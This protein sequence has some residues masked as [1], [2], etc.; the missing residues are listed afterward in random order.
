MII[1]V[2]DSYI[3]GY[4]VRSKA[5]SSSSNCIAVNVVLERLCF[6]FNGIPG[7]LSQSDKSPSDC[8]IE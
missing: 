7:S 4:C 6:R 5:R 1:I 8:F 3:S 2:Y